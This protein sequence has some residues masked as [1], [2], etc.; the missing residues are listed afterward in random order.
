M[1]VIGRQR[2]TGLQDRETRQAVIE[3]ELAHGDLGI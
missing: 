1:F 2:L 3:E